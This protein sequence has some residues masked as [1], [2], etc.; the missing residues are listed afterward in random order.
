MTTRA[1]AAPIIVQPVPR[2]ISYTPKDVTGSKE[3]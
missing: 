1:A 3:V 2:T